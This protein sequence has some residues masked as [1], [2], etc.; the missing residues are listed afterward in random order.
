VART[1]T[2]QA[3]T[4]FQHA[5]GTSEGKYGTYGSAGY[6]KAC[7]SLAHIRNSTRNLHSA[8]AVMML[9]QPLAAQC[10]APTV[11]VTR[12]FNTNTSASGS[13]LSLQDEYSYIQRGTRR[14]QPKAPEIG[15]AQMESHQCV[16]RTWVAQPTVGGIASILCNVTC[17]WLLLASWHGRSPTIRAIAARVQGCSCAHGMI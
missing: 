13:R 1:R 9:K 16:S 10:K 7:K 17:V 5:H 3:A 15:T 6:R 4:W 12:E 2:R 11:S 14:A 8:S